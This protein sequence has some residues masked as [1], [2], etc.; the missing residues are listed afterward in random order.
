M[1]SARIALRLIFLLSPMSGLGQASMPPTSSPSPANAAPISA[2]AQPIVQANNERS[3]D[4]SAKREAE[5]YKLLYDGQ[6]EANKDLV[7]VMYWAIGLVAAFILAIAGSQVIFNYRLRK[8]EID[9]IKSENSKTITQSLNTAKNEIAGLL[10]DSETESRGAR[11]ELSKYLSGRIDSSDETLNS[12]K[13]ELKPLKRLGRKLNL[14]EIRLNDAEA[15]VWRLR[16]VESN[17]LTKFM[18]SCDLLIKNNQ[19]N[20]LI[21]RL[22]DIEEGLENSDDIWEQDYNELKALMEKIPEQ[23]H[24]E[25]DKILEIAEKLPVYVFDDANDPK[26]SWTYIRNVPPK[27]EEGADDE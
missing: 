12:I 22:E 10:R 23:F 19:P 7:Q 20:R 6:K 15:H 11:E 3:E 13:D 2:P 24:A 8:S 16:G 14:L 27:D 4:L 9:R 21:H 1:L 17:A 5:F 25:R 26:S 18:R